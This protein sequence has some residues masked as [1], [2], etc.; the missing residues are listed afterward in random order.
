MRKRTIAG[1]VLA[2]AAL[3]TVWRRRASSTE[4]ISPINEPVPGDEPIN[5]EDIPEDRT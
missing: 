1:L 4:E 2:A 5:E 3:V